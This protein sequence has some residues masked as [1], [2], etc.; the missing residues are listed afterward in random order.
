MTSGEKVRRFRFE[1]RVTNEEIA[2]FAGVSGATI[3][4]WISENKK[5]KFDVIA[6]VAEFIGCSMDDL[7]DD[8]E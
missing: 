6:K 8:P 4:R 7:K 2:E 5:P 3:S 1:L